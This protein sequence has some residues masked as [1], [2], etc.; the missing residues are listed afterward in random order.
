DV[1]RKHDLTKIAAQV[2]WSKITGRPGPRALWDWS[3]LWNLMQLW[4]VGYPLRYRLRVGVVS[5]DSHDVVYR[6]YEAGPNGAEPQFLRAAFASGVQPVIGLVEDLEGMPAA[7]DGGVWNV[8]PIGDVLRWDP[9]H[10]M[11]FDT[12]PHQLGNDKPGRWFV[13]DLV[14]VLDILLSGRVHVDLERALQVNELVDQAER[15]GVTLT[16]SDGT[17]YRRFEFTHVTMPSVEWDSMDFDRGLPER[18]EIGYERAR[19]VLG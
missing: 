14:R 12:G 1:Y 5:L 9:D 15:K 6:T 8:T 10:V 13:D 2:A 11:I 3:P 19:E 16:K 17:P 4:A 7:C 18:W